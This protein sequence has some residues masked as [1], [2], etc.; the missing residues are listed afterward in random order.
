MIGGI[1]IT[2]KTV[3]WRE[4]GRLIYSVFDKEQNTLLWSININLI[5]SCSVALAHGLV[6]FFFTRLDSHVRI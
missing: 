3:R 6:W 4:V 1:F 5:L 2:Q